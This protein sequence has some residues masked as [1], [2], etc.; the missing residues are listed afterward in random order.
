M[1]KNE[2]NP[3]KN[4]ISN[5]IQDTSDKEV[6]D[7]LNLK[8]KKVIVKKNQIIND[9]PNIINSFEMRKLKALSFYPLPIYCYL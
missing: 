1:C 7:F 8:L 2:K 5:Y 9:L 6:I 4:T 3:Y